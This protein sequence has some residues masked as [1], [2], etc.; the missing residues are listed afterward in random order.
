MSVPPYCRTLMVLQN[1]TFNYSR[2]AESYLMEPWSSYSEPDL[3]KTKDDISP[4]A[5]IYETKVRSTQSCRTGDSG[6][7][8]YCNAERWT[9]D[10]MGQGSTVVQ[11]RI[12]WT[13]QHTNAYNDIIQ[14]HVV[15]R[16]KICTGQHILLL[17]HL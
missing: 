15:D 8:L 13:T 2:Y 5:F 12:N 10:Q 1:E 11:S 3:S 6:K 17:V 9:R 4:F 7:G 16:T 14:Q